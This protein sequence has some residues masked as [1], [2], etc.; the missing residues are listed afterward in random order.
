MSFEKI[1][2]VNQE[3]MIHP[4]SCVML[5]Y[6]TPAELK[7]IQVVAKMVGISDQIILGTQ[8]AECTLQAILDNEITTAEGH[9]IKQK[10]VVFNNVA[11]TRINAFIEGLKKFRINKPLMAV[12]TENSIKWTL[13]QLLIELGEE[14]RALKN[15]QW[16]NH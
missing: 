3:E 13:N 4:R 8:Q 15:N 14:H 7:Q 9:E 16:N 5:Y 11:G 1:G 6:F 10:A 2:A 12:V